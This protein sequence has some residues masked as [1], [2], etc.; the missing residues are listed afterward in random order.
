M[1]LCKA[2][3]ATCRLKHPCIPLYAYRSCA[4]DFVFLNDNRTVLF[5]TL[6]SDTHRPDKVGSAF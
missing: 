3:C 1:P 5:S 4:G 6:T 2:R